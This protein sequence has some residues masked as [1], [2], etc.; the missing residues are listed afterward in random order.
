MVNLM[1]EGKL[2]TAQM[3]VQRRTKNL[4]FFRKYYPEL[5]NVFADFRMMRTELVV[6]PDEPDVDLVVEGTALYHGKAWNYAKREVD[7]FIRVNH[8]GRKMKTYSPPL[9]RIY[10]DYRFANRFLKEAA[11][12]SDFNKI[13]FTGYP[14][15][16]FYPFVVFLGCGLGYQI[17]RLTSEAD[18]LNAIIFEPNPEIFS[19]SLFTV[20]WEL[21]CNRF[22][23]RK[24]ASLVF[25][26]GLGVDLEGARNLLERD[27]SNWG[28]FY[29]AL[30]LFFNHLGSAGM[31]EMAD[32]VMKDIPSFLA[33]WGSYDDEVRRLN[34]ALHNFSTPFDIIIPGSEVRCDKPVVVVGSGPSVDDRIHDLADVRDNVILVS[35]GTGIRVLIKHGLKPDYHVELDPDYVIYEILSELSESLSGITLLAVNEVNPRV[36]ELFEKK[37]LYFKREN[38]HPYLL[39]YEQFCFSHCNPT[40]TNAALAIFIGLGYEQFFLFGTDYG[41]RSVEHHHSKSSIYGGGD[42]GPISNKLREDAKGI[43]TERSTFFIPAIDGGTIRTRADLYTAKRSVEKLIRYCRREGKN[44]QVVNC[45]TGALIEGAPAMDAVSFARSIREHSGQGAETDPAL[46][47]KQISLGVAELDSCLE[48]TDQ[49]MKRRLEA[50]SQLLEQARLDGKK[51]MALLIGFLA[52]ELNVNRHRTLGKETI[53]A[54]F[55][56]QHLLQGTLMHFLAIGLCNTL[57]CDNDEQGKSFA[58]AWRKTF[59]RFLES[60][61]PHFQLIDGHKRTLNEDLWLTQGLKS[62]E[63]SRL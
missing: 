8:P 30:V 49:V 17:D 41:F 50:M 48:R 3:Y 26:L 63:P 43:Y 29:P 27:I 24:G 2:D 10:S 46:K 53:G 54:Q 51:D 37:H 20:D 6:S 45:A 11:S 42:A 34:N 52:K 38:P 61:R 18:V 56:A 39:G 57:A 23:K 1:A 16:N 7:E 32:S 13:E 4:E 47:T 55:M 9:E 44:V 22:R 25:S 14:I 12:H 5:Y 31:K 36:L 19:A 35:A 62:V 59:V 58:R 60:V 28:P 40:C 21:I 33:G 15:S